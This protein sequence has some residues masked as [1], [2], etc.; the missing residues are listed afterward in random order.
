MN[1]AT[2]E[3]LD[4]LDNLIAIYKEQEKQFHDNGMLD[5]EI[6]MR[7]HREMTEHK[8]DQFKEFFKK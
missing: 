2:K 1:K 7:A 5:L 8:K 4:K 3:L 6:T